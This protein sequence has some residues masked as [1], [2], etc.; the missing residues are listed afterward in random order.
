ELNELAY[1]TVPLGNRLPVD[2]IHKIEIIRGPGSARYGG[3]AELAV[4]NIITKVGNGLEGAHVSLIGGTTEEHLSRGNI[5]L[6]AGR[7]FSDGFYVGAFAYGG[8]ALRSDRS[9]T[10]LASPQNTFDMERDSGLRP[11]L[12]MLEVQAGGFE[13]KVMTEWYR[14]V[15]RDNYETALEEES[16]LDFGSLIVDSAY[17]WKA[18]EWSLTPYM[19]FAAQRPWQY[20]VTPIGGSAAVYHTTFARFLPGFQAEGDLFEDVHALLGGEYSLLTAASSADS[21]LTKFHRFAGFTEFSGKIPVVE[22]NL[23]AGVRVEHQEEF[24]TAAAPRAALTRSFGRFHL[25]GLYSRGYR[26]P[27]IANIWFN[28]PIDAE[29]ADV[30]EVEG[31][32]RVTDNVSVTA[33]FFDVTIRDPFIY[34][35][36]PGPPTIDQYTNFE[37]TGSR[38]AETEIRIKGEMGYATINYSFATTA[39]KN[40]VPLYAV[41]G[42]TD[43]LLAFPQHKIAAAGSLSLTRQLSINPSLVF[44]SK[45]YGYVGDGAGGEILRRF[46]PE[47]IADLNIQ[48]DDALVEGLSVSLA[49]HNLSDEETEFITAYDVFHAPIPGMSR[50]Y[51]LRITYEQ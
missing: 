19:K 35:Y 9:Y 22:I 26:S 43:Q 12:G 5:S 37:R 33:N 18:G 21:V 8:N 15:Q 25:K 44:L 46:G 3:A 14:I 39:G 51:T 4:I 1:A 2:Q 36:D 48:Y 28:P 41:A 34:Y 50:E 13:G 16:N 17:E 6:A 49:V 24:G 7:R 45:R 42:R 31:G 23:T 32:A 11:L 30:F 27:G 40:R 38:G 47:V 10:D 20:T 29:K